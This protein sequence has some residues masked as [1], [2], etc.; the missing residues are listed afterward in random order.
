MIC[1]CTRYCSQVAARISTFLNL[2]PHGIDGAIAGYRSL[3]PWLRL[4]NRFPTRLTAASKS[5]ALNGLFSRCG[6]RAI[7]VP[8]R[9]PGFGAVDQGDGAEIEVIVAAGTA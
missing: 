9:L 3:G 8:A 5:Q 1:A 6:V 7:T 4:A 2:C